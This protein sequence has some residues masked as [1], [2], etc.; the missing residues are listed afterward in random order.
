MSRDFRGRTP[1][2]TGAAIGMRAG[3]GEPLRAV[4]EPARMV[5]IAEGCGFAVEE[6]PTER[7]L[8]D[9]FFRSRP[10]GPRPTVPARVI[11]ARRV[12]TRAAGGDGR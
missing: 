5:A 1:V 9:L 2:V 12:A 6:H 7:D 11:V 8:A 10:T 4:Y 3:D